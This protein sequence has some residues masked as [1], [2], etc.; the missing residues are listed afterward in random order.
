MTVAAY[1]YTGWHPTPERDASFH[2]G[3]TEWELVAGC[4]PRFE[5]HQQ[6]RRPALGT[7]DDRDPAQVEH[8]LA[9]AVEH[10]VEAFV[11][12]FFYMC[13]IPIWSI[14]FS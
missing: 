5:G 14:I 13:L 10:G 9:L 6:P 4:T 8:R 11:H 12:G 2:P 1:V 3:F 7:Y